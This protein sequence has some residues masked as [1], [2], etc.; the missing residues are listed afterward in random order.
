[1][2]Q[3]QPKDEEM[4]EG[5]ARSTRCERC[6]DKHRKCEFKTDADSCERCLDGDHDC[7]VPG[8]KKR[9][10]P[11][12]VA[13]HTTTTSLDPEGMTRA[14]MAQHPDSVESEGEESET[15]MEEGGAS[16]KPHIPCQR[17][18]KSKIRC[19]FKTETDPCKRCFNGGHDCVIPGRKKQQSA[20]TPPK[21]HLLS[22]IREQAAEI[23][24]LMTQL[25]TTNARQRP[26]DTL[27]LTRSS[28]L[29][30]LVLTP[31]S[32]S[33]SHFS[34]D[35]GSK[36]EAAKEGQRVK[37]RT[38]KERAQ[39]ESEDD[40]P[41][42]KRAPTR[43]IQ[44]QDEIENEEPAPTR[45]QTLKRK[46]DLDDVPEAMQLPEKKKYQMSGPP[47]F[48]YAQLP[49]YQMSGPPPSFGYTQG[50]VHSAANAVPWSLTTQLPQYQMSAPPP[51]FDYTQGAARSSVRAVPRSSLPD[52]AAPV[53]L[54][55]PDLATYDLGGH[56]PPQMWTYASPF[57]SQYVPDPDNPQECMYHP[58]APFSF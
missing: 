34:F 27:P 47:S 19:E 18:K 36:N 54:P 29:R 46:R 5:G 43:K 38:G 17:C 42:P 12:S 40:E 21:V 11:P 15:E 25:E 6:R 7:V 24:K 30:S 2:A 51:S 37:K 31:T 9:K 1:M 48:D 45:K 8:R 28:G 16:A 33:T 52:H 58:P 50:A 41:E 53:L 57:A 20:Q 39:A 49:Q 3:H 4:E 10:T 22:Q 35:V 56:E 44:Q 26:L 23:Q 32:E 13:S 14:I 55:I